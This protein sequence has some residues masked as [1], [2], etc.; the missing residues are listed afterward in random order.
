MFRLYAKYKDQKRFK[1]V[2]WSTGLM[3]TNLIYATLFTKEEKKLVE[4]DLEKNKELNQEFIFKF[5]E[6]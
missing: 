2:D 5:K 3:V 4:E 1:P 6:I